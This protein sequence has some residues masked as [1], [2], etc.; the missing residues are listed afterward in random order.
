MLL[1]EE[2]K[3]KLAETL[4]EKGIRDERVLKAIYDIPREKFISSALRRF[5]YD[6]NALP[7][8]CAQTISQ[9]FTVAFM[10]QVMEVQPGDRILEIGTGSGYQ[11]AVLSRLGAEVY[12]VERI[13]KLHENAKSLLAEL[14]YN[15]FLKL[16]D[17]TLGWKEFAPY[18]KIIVTAGAPDIPNHLVEQLA[19]NGKLIV[20][21]GDQQSQRLLVVTNLE[22]GLA[23]KYYDYFKFVPLIGEDGWKA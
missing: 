18:D 7:I 14:G 15:V 22:E 4:W 23:K 5:A 11:A 1:L 20:P 10:T 17:G 13:E 21:V 9:P 6:D 8:E 16:D 3:R 2:E 19:G 12:S